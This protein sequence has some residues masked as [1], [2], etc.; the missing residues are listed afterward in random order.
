MIVMR[1]YHDENKFKRNVIKSDFWMTISSRK[2]D[3]GLTI[4]I[5]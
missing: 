1:Y 4:Y 5:G 3:L 2:A